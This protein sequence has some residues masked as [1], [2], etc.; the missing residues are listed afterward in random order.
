MLTV[1]RIA[2]LNISLNDLMKKKK[3]L[4]NAIVAAALFC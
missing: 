1:S 2:T 3:G 4:R